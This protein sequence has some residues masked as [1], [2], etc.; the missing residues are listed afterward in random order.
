[1]DID[2]KSPD[3]N[4][5]AIMSYVRLLLHEVN[6]QDEWP[7][8]QKRMMSGDYDNVCAVAEEVTFGSIRV[9][10]RGEDD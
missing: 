9:V 10:N 5:F 7:D 4:A 3:G 2:A 1:M 6:R 8:A